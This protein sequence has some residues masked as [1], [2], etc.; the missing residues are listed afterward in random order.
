MRRNLHVILCFSPVGEAFA[1]RPRR[2]PALVNC[3]VIDWFHPWPEEA[4]L[5]VARRFLSEVDLGGDQVRDGIVRFMP[6]AFKCV[7]EVSQ[8]YLEVERRY[9]YTTPKSFLGVI[10]LYQNMLSR[11]RSELT[12]AIERL[13]SGLEKLIK[14]SRDVSILEE[15]LKIKSVEVEEKKEQADAFAE[16]V[17]QE[18]AKVESENDKAKIEES[19]CEKIAADVKAQQAECAKQLAEAEPAVKRAEAALDTVTKKDLGETKALKTPPA[20]I[21]DITGAIIVLLS[22]KKGVAKDRSWKAAVNVMNQVDKFLAVLRN[23]KNEID[24]GN[25]P[26]ANFVA[27]RPY[28]ALPHFKPDT[29]KGKSKACAGLCEWVLNIV[30][31]YDIVCKVE[32]LRQALAK[33]EQELKEAEENLRL[34]KEK[35]A[36]LQAQL[37]TL[38]E[39]FDAAVRDK[40]A[41]IAEA[42]RCRAK[43]ELAQRL[44]RAVGPEQERWGQNVETL[45]KDLD[46]VAGDVLLAAAFV[47]YIG[48]FSKTFRTELLSKYWIPFL[49]QNKVPLSPTTDVLKILT[50]E[51]EMAGWQGD[52]LPSDRVSLENGVIV[53]NCERWPLIVDPQ[54]QGIKWIKNKEAR[55]SLVVLRLGQNRML[56]KLEMAIQNGHSVLIE[57]MGQQI[58]AVL[59]PVIA[60]QTIKKLGVLYVRLG[61][62]EVEYNKNFKLFLH[63]KLS[64]PHYPPEI[65]AE[66]TLINFTVTEE[67]LED[68]LLAVVVSKERLDLEEMKAKL[69]TEQNE[70]KIKLK[71]LEDGLLKRLAAAQGDLTEDVELIENLEDMKRISDDIKN[72]MRIATVTEVKINKTREIYRPVAARGALLFFLLMNLRKINT[73]YQYSLAAFKTVFLRGI[74]R[75]PKVV[76]QVAD[77]AAE[78]AEATPAAPA[79]TAPAAAAD[80][81]AAV[82][83]AVVADA[84]LL[85]RINGLIGSITYAVF[86]HTG[87]SV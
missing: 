86:Q 22:D 29:I 39:Q 14:T 49:M 11:R 31:Y 60:R 77:A 42:N 1:I 36:V 66:T 15:D 19:K 71:E 2:F 44:I 27:V 64:N 53:N 79:A 37:A 41:A 87:A 78:G 85:E 80:G 68:Q 59:L 18:K 61:D 55:N 48:Y 54:L 74:D 30:E 56:N 84:A 32:P 21:D 46:V 65:Q 58:D 52:M 83:E 16:T 17:G 40:E 12:H 75:L 70:F 26:A 63:T 81:T 38:V 47:S 25:V 10:H 4:L 8:R 23:F 51:A 67:G 57:N 3:T 72:R 69:I 62:H 34:V 24:A 9:N 33:A 45:N 6:Y 20:G 76:E 28:I 50:D 43:L 35:V 7:N 73:F 5:G 13:Q 82:E